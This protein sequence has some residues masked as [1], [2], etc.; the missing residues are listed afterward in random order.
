MEVGLPE[1]PKSFAK[2]PCQNGHS[3][4][5]E[6]QTMKVRQSRKSG[7]LENGTPKTMTPPPFIVARVC[8]WI[9]LLAKEVVQFATAT[10]LARRIGEIKCAPWEEEPV[11]LPSNRGSCDKS[12][13]YL[14]YLLPPPCIRRWF[15]VCIRRYNPIFTGCT[16]TV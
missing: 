4:L 12:V 2:W 14:Q 9:A 6:R 5:H 13:V 3:D 16:P 15:W 1:W 10:L 7:L 8:Q 11:S